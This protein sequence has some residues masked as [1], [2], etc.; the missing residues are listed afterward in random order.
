MY[1]LRSIRPLAIAGAKVGFVFWAARL[2]QTGL[3]VIDGCTAAIISHNCEK[4][5]RISSA[6]IC[7][8]P[9]WLSTLPI[10]SD[11]SCLASGR[12]SAT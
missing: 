11:H 4:Q 12:A 3:F 2:Q 9:H 1:N 6:M 10:C 7:E 8:S 5:P